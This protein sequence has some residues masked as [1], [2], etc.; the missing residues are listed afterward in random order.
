[1]CQEFVTPG[2]AAANDRNDR[3]PYGRGTAG[4]TREGGE[5]QR[6]I[7]FTIKL[8]GL[9]FAVAAMAGPTAQARL[10]PGDPVGGTNTI[11]PAD[12]PPRAPPPEASFAFRTWA[13]R[14]WKNIPE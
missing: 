14:Q 10:D 2:V 12:R 8:I 6:R 7:R 9:G 13:Q 11:R 1:L 4:S 5:M 3:P